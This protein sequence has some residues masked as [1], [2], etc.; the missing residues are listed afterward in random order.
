MPA[1]MTRVVVTIV[2]G[3]LS[4]HAT[5]CPAQLLE[6]EI[7]SKASIAQQDSSF[8]IP[9]SGALIGDYDPRTNP[10]GTQT[11]PG[12]FG[13]SGNIPIDYSATFMTSGSLQSNPAGIFQFQVDL[14]SGT[15][16]ISGLDLDLLAG[17]VGELGTS[18]GISW[19]TFRSFDPGSIF[20]EPPFPLEIPLGGGSINVF[21]MTQSELAGGFIITPNRDGTWNV[22][23]AV[24]VLTQVE[25]TI[26]DQTIIPPATPGL[27]PIAGTLSFEGDFATLQ[28]LIQSEFEDQVDPGLPPFE[29]I[30]LELPTILP[31]GDFAGLLM[32]GQISLVDAM[33]SLDTDIIAVATIGAEPIPG[34]LNGDDLVNGEDLGIMLSEWGFCPGCIADLDG[35]EQVNGIDLGILLANWSI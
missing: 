8:D 21:T 13:G 32:S 27:L 20:F 28:I 19:Q 30:P 14:E 34:D 15:G 31:P 18:L 17:S 7:D 12:L 25:L 4:L 1:T 23:G 16:T 2:F 11:R 9:F 35:D 6:F 33:T 5:E 10:E 29:G 3:T 26:F 22:A 24:P